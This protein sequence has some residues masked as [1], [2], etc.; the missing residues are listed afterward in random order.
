MIR[1]ENMKYECIENFDIQK[2]DDDG[3]E[4]ENAIFVI[5][6]GS[7]WELVGYAEK[8]DEYDLIQID[9]NKYG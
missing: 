1:G 8:F 4:I 5:K 7:T 9:K 6:K 2:V 3:F